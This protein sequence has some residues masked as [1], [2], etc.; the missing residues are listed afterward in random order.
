MK[1]KPIVVEF[2]GELACFSAPYA[3]V[4]RLSYPAPTPTA[5]IGMLSAIYAKPAEFCWEIEKIEILN[6]IKYLSIQRNESK[7]KLSS[8][9]LEPIDMSEARTQRQTIA[10]KNPRYR[11]TAHIVPRKGQ[12]GRLD[13]LVEQ[14]ERRIKTGQ[15]YYQPSMGLRE[16]PG[17]FE[18]SD[19]KRN[20]IPVDIDMGFVVHDLWDIDDWE[21]KDNYPVK[22]TMFHCF[23]NQGVINVP[24]RGSREIIR[25][26]E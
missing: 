15:C 20:P 16:F 2:W 8:R 6:P 17:Y 24:E 9:T 14:A 18:L 21:P 12:E 23:A 7:E 11:I 1:S 3:R 5:A 25:G 19:G 4:E 10:M 13:K 22:R 26:G